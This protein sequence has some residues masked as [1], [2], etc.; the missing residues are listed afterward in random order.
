MT[1]AEIHE[2]DAAGET[3]AI[4]A[5]LRQEL[6][7]PLVNLIWR[8]FAALPGVL[9]WAWSTVRPV[10]R[11][12]EVLQG[13]DRMGQRLWQLAGDMAP[14]LPTLTAD[15]AAVVDIYNRGN[16][17]NLQ[18]LTALRK[19]MAGQAAGGGGLLE[20]QSGAP[21]PL[22]S[23]PGM[24]RLD[25]LEPETSLMVRKLAALHGE[26]GAR[27]IP[28]LYRHLALWPD[29]LPPLHAALSKVSETGL[30]ADGRSVLIDMADATA[31]R[32]LPALRPPGVFPAEQREATLGAL[33]AFTGRLIADLSVVG[34]LL[35]RPTP[36]RHLR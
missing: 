13:Q 14:A 22:A 7:L 10:M 9:P 32:L 25:R 27:A 18:L 21:A 6:G 19:A 24:P 29:L 17:T 35:R 34:L 8:H 3:A 23:V 5:E 30:L 12:L 31:A 20:R 15:Q 26:E 4:Y 36:V 11:S 16:T 2:A 1:I 33:E 28:S